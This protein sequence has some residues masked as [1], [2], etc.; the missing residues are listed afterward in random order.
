MFENMKTNETMRQ[1]LVSLAYYRVLKKKILT[2][3]GSLNR[4]NKDF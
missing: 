1:F 4:I 3:K 2:V